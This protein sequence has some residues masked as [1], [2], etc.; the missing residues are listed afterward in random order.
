MKYKNKKPCK[1]YSKTCRALGVYENYFY[2]F[3]IGNIKFI[4]L[5]NVAALVDVLMLKFKKGASITINF[6]VIIPPKSLGKD[7]NLVMPFILMVISATLVNYQNY[8]ETIQL[9][10]LMFIIGLN[11]HLS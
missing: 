10:K 3:Y 1:F 4:Y 11:Q 7:K 2:V 8:I 6:M 9:R 5:C